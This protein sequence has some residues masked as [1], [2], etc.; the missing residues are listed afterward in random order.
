MLKCAILFSFQ[1]IALCCNGQTK[2]IYRADNAILVFDIQS[3]QRI[4]LDTTLWENERLLS[5]V[6]HRDSLL[7]LF[8]KNGLTFTRKYDV[9]KIGPLEE[10]INKTFV[11]KI[12]QNSYYFHNFYFKDYRLIL[13]SNN[14]ISLLKGDRLLWD[15][16]LNY[17]FNKSL[18]D[19]RK[20][21]THTGFKYPILSPDE[22]HF[23]VTSYR[24]NSLTPWVKLYE[25]DMDNGEMRLIRKNAHNPSYSANGQYILLSNYPQ[26]LYYII[27]R[28]A[29]KKLFDYGFEDA[30]W[31]TME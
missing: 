11:H 25:V 8:K 29:N 31:L 3:Q 10:K 30:F 2:I 6:A 24:Y 19:S 28:A 5:V 1:L 21:S 16:F 14:G 22:N 13:F 20:P 12:N 15:G 4:I 17:R 18:E 27:D 7:C 9:D 26:G 23:L